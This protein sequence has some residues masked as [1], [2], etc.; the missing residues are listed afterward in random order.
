MYDFYFGTRE[1]IESDPVRFLLTIKR[2]LPRWPNGIPDSEFIALYNLLDSIEKERPHLTSSSHVLVETGSG[3]STIVL[4]YF[5]IRWNTE[6]YSWD[7]SGNKLS[8]LRGMLT[9]TLFKHFADKNIFNHW[10]YVPYCSTSEY[11]GIPILGEKG[12]H[13]SFCFL[14]SDHT[15]VNLKGE[16]ECL[17]PLLT[18]GSV[19]SIDDGNYRY[20]NV[21][22][23]YVNMLRHKHGLASVAIAD[24]ECATFHEET[25]SL[26]KAR[27][28]AV[29][30]LQGGTYRKEY[31]DDIFWSYYNSDR[32]NMTD[33]GMEK[34]DELAHRFDAWMVDDEHK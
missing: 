13:V 21:N 7:I 28:A 30:D 33:L 31:K 17:C 25:M 10:K 14:D 9:D 8:Y 22:E 4:L 11:A 6:L 15:W 34:M 5:A 12:K 29:R 3:A 27:F 26:L 24:N 19:V 20:R 16:L 23:A 1:Q 18:P 2:M 32:K